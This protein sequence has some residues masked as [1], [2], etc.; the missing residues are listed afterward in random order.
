MATFSDGY[1]FIFLM[2]LG[3]NNFKGT[4]RVGRGIS[5]QLLRWIA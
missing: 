2:A 5:D 3:M 1:G 4:Q